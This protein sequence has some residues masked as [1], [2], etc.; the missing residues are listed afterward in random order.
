MARSVNDAGLALIKQWEGRRLTAYRD[1]VGVW[2][3][4]YGHTDAA[5]PP[6]VKR[7][8]KITEAQAEAMLR[9]DLAQYEAAV[10][11]AV[12]VPLSDNQFAALVSFCF[13]VGSGNFR[14]S[15]LLKQL[16]AGDRAAVPGE[17]AK[18]NRAGGKVLAG[19]ANRRAAEAGLWARGDFVASN[20]VE[21][22]ARPTTGAGLEGKGALTATLGT[23]G[24]MVTEA[25]QQLSPFA[26]MSRI[27]QQAF[28]ALTVLG[29][30]LSLLGALRRAREEAGL[31]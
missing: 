6:A 30:G 1:P 29:I 23:V 25:A 10:E 2:T 20:Y 19:L 17:L 15:T 4:G 11:E 13:N 21:P 28:V 3:I 9:A 22:A 7:G 18:W 5:G 8:Q 16:N 31:A 24:A 26:E 14:A 12:D 27:A